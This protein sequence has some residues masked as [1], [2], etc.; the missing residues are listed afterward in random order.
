M[1]LH[2]I[3]LSQL[4]C[5]MDQPDIFKCTMLWAMLPQPRYAGRTTREKERSCPTFT[6]RPLAN[7]R[8]N[9]PRRSSRVSRAIC[10][11]LACT[12]S[13]SVCST[14]ICTNGLSQQHAPLA[15]PQLYILTG[16]PASQRHWT[17][18]AYICAAYTH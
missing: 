6:R 14:D 16:S 3:A 15:S 7:A 8:G 2:A 9:A 4:L 11:S 1:P 10:L 17:I 18:C 12:K 13:V 5:H